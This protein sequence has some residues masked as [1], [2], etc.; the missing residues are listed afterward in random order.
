MK[1]NCNVCDFDFESKYS[2]N[3]ERCF[4]EDITSEEE[5]DRQERAIKYYRYNRRKNFQNTIRG[6]R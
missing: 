2:S 1:Y 4:S 6:H 5:K 3:C